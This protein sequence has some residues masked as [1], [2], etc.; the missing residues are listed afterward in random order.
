MLLFNIKNMTIQRNFLYLV[1]FISLS[2]LAFSICDNIHILPDCSISTNDADCDGYGAGSGGFYG[3]NDPDDNNPLVNQ[4]SILFKDND[5][6][7]V[8]YGQVYPSSSF[9]TSINQFVYN[10]NGNWYK[11]DVDGT[12]RQI[13]GLVPALV[14][15]TTGYILNPELNKS[16][17]CYDYNPNINSS[18]SGCDNDEDGKINPAAFLDDYFID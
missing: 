11:Y 7:D 3:T 15:S 13:N 8:F 5:L 6:D 4:R 10:I 12:C 17:D 16:F 1:F 9:I 14:L 18:S 2:S